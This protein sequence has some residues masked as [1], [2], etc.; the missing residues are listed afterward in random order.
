MKWKIGIIQN[1]NDI[2]TE[3][4]LIIDTNIDIKFTNDYIKKDFGVADPFIYDKYI[5]AEAI[6]ENLLKIQINNGIKKNNQY[7]STRHKGGIIVVGKL[8]KKKEIIF[9]DIISDK[10]FHLSYPL[11]FKYN[12]N[13]YMIPE[14]YQAVELK[15]YKCI[16]FPF[17]WEF[18]KKIL[19]GGYCDSTLF[20][21]KDYYYIFTRTVKPDLNM[22]ETYLFRTKDILNENLILYKKN[23][24]PNGYRGGG[25]VFNMNNKLYIPIQPPSIPYG[26]NLIIYEIIYNN[27]DISFKYNNKICISDNFNGIHHISNYNNTFICDYY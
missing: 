3:N 12:N 8:N 19:D 17:K 18:E 22:C 7:K 26:K 2:L 23:I 6:N 14:T 1:N 21:I 16:Q 9:S 24:L 4:V 25:N 20:K 10:N 15:L 5:F 11:V 13:S 27:N